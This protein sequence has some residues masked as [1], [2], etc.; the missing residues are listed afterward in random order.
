VDPSS[1][2]DNGVGDEEANE[3]AESDEES[4]GTKLSMY[5]LTGGTSALFS[6]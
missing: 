1:V 6:H 2:I 5:L 4:D 3:G